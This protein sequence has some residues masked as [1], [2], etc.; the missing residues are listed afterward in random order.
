[1]REIHGFMGCEGTTLTTIPNPKAAFL[2]MSL[3]LSATRT[4][5]DTCG[6]SGAS[7]I[8]RFL[9]RISVGSHAARPAEGSCTRHCDAGC[10]QLPL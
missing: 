4:W 2:S 10:I 3:L 8:E 6:K 1:M 5:N 7:D 9:P